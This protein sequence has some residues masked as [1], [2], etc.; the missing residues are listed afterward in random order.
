GVRWPGPGTRT[1]KDTEALHR[2]GNPLSRRASACRPPP[3]SLR[4]PTGGRRQRVVRRFVL[5]HD[6]AAAAIHVGR[7]VDG[8]ARARAVSQTRRV[9]G[10]RAQPR[11][12]AGASVLRRGRLAGRDRAYLGLGLGARAARSTAV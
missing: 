8:A 9:L 1:T 11:G 2:E 6:D 10:R 4:C 3:P 7:L 12:G 5:R